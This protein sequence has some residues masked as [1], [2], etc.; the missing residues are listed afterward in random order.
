MMGSPEICCILLLIFNLQLVRSCGPGEYNFQD[1]CCSMCPPGT[2]VS[3]H[4]TSTSAT[5]CIPCARGAYMDH[6]NGLEKCLKCKY[7]DPELGLDT[8]QE[9]SEIQDAVCDCKEGYFCLAKTKDRCHMCTKYI[10][11][12]FN[13]SRNDKGAPKQH[14]VK[15]TPQ[16]VI[17]QANV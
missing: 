6:Q 2:R 1:L 8:V 12:F 3:K 10:T 13:E 14:E 11:P 7:C 9:C 16:S 5:I 4:C 15:P 17:T